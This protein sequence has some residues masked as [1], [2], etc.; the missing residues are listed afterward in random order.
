MH[1]P[2]IYAT[3]TGGLGDD[4]VARSSGDPASGIDETTALALLNSCT[5][6]PDAKGSPRTLSVVMLDR[7]YGPSALLLAA[8]LVAVLLLGLRRRIHVSPAPISATA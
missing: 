1:Q 6:G 4:F 2:L 5:Q 7:D 3:E 8:T